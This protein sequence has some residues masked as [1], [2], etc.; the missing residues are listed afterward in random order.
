MKATYSKIKQ[1][2]CDKLGEQVLWDDF[3]AFVPVSAPPLSSD[4]VIS[5][6]SRSPV[7]NCDAQQTRFTSSNFLAWQTADPLACKEHSRQ[8]TLP[9]DTHQQ[10][11]GHGVGPRERANSARSLKKVRAVGGR[12]SALK[13]QL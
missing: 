13:K 7:F 4:S 5:M 12:D 9:P 11:H 1:R 8:Q 6:C 2:Y 10:V 3:D